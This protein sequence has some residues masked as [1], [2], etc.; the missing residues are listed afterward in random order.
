MRKFQFAHIHEIW[1]HARI[2]AKFHAS[3]NNFCPNQAS[4]TNIS[5]PSWYVIKGGLNREE[6]VSCRGG[7]ETTRDRLRMMS[8]IVLRCSWKCP[9]SPH[10][11]HNW[12]LDGNDRFYQIGNKSSH[13]RFGTSWLVS[14]AMAS[15]CSLYAVYTGWLSLS[16]HGHCSK[17]CVNFLAV[18]GYFKLSALA[19]VMPWSFS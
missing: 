13:D 5:T 9:S 10:R 6:N 12:P 15:F 16:F 19:K 4:R 18:F 2:L 8:M 11:G 7:T 17:L 3:R 1:Y 14:L